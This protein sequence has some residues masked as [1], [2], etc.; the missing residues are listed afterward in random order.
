MEVSSVEQ[1]KGK[2]SLPV[3]SIVL[4]MREI[5]GRIQ[6]ANCPSLKI[7][8]IESRPDYNVIDCMMIPGCWGGPNYVPPLLI[9]S[10]L[11]GHW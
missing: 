5:S 6:F 1:G 11:F 3:G 7:L 8:G 4:H 2:R 10:E 9:V